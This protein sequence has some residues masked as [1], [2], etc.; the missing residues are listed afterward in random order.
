MDL[1]DWAGRWRLDAERT[2]ITT[3][4][5]TF[6][7]FVHVKSEFDAVDGDAQVDGDKLTG[8]LRIDAASVRTGIKRRDA[9]LRSADFFDVEAFPTVEVVAESG[10]VTS[11]SWVTLHVRLTVKGHESEL[12]LP[13]HVR[14]LGGGAV[15][16][17]TTATLNRRNL[18]VDGN[19]LGMM[20]DAAG[21]EAA[22]VFVRQ[23]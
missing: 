17:S 13:V 7:G 5:P 6:W 23:P 21:V 19:L 20:G 12:D 15:Q 9:H 16:L 11:P 22:A 10:E 2:T 8:T 3:H 1:Q 18:G 14:N 4:S